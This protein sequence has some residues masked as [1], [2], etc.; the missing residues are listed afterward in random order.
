MGKLA[1]ECRQFLRLGRDSIGGV[2][3]SL[4]G[5]VRLRAGL[6]RAQIHLVVQ[7]ANSVERRVWQQVGQILDVGSAG[8]KLCPELELGFAQRGP[9]VLM[10]E[11]EFGLQPAG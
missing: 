4:L 1:R 8:P 9:D 3:R 10:A 11:R 7:L 2:V 5:F 6:V